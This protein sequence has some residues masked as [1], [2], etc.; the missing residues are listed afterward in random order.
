MA[1]V[2][3]G[4]LASGPDHQR[5]KQQQQQQQQQ[6]LDAQFLCIYFIIYKFRATP[7]SSSGESIL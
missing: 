2:Q 4:A 7:F 5:Q 6:Q 3:T 1:A